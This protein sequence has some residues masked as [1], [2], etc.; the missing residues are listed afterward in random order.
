MLGEIVHGSLGSP[1]S[2][3]RTISGSDNVNPKSSLTVEL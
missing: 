1:S 2:N 3:A